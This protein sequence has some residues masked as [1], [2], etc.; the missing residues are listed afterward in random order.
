MS[1][2]MQMRRKREYDMKYSISH[3]SSRRTFT[4]PKTSK[5]RRR[6]KTAL[7]EGIF[8]VRR[9]SSTTGFY[10]AIFQ[11]HKCYIAA[12]VVLRIGEC[13]GSVGTKLQSDP[14][15]P[16]LK[17]GCSALQSYSRSEKNL[18]SSSKGKFTLNKKQ[19]FLYHHTSGQIPGGVT[20][21]REM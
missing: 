9:D 3:F 18:A 17:G 21:L 8:T 13:Y 10:T 5:L 19:L 2:E 12:Q 15:E 1:G 11:T 14:I 7:N 6:K 20:C 4:G 16:N